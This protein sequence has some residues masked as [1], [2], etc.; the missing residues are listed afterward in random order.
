MAKFTIDTGV[1]PKKISPGGYT[2]GSIYTS[3]TLSTATATLQWK[4]EDGNYIDFTDGVL[5]INDEI[6][7]PHGN[8]RDVYVDVSGSDGSTLFY[9]MY[10]GFK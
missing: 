7:L 9:V 1:T 10:N 8:E 2:N 5:T 6:T 3:G 4:D